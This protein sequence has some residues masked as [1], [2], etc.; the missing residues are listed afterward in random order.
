MLQF[1]TNRCCSLM[2]S[3]QKHPVGQAQHLHLCSSTAWRWRMQQVTE[4]GVLPCQEGRAPTLECSQGGA[5]TST[6]LQKP[7]EL[8]SPAAGLPSICRKANSAH[9]ACSKDCALSRSTRSY[10]SS[11]S[12]DQEKVSSRSFHKPWAVTWWEN[13]KVENDTG[14]LLQLVLSLCGKNKGPAQMS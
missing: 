4:C 14:R 12:S 3:D 11:H 1:C 8:K 13:R 2:E 7:A 5:S 6:I 10:C 9:Q